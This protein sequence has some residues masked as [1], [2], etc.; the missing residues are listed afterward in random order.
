MLT[1]MNASYPSYNPDY[2]GD[3]PGKQNAIKVL[4][5]Q[6]QGNKVEFRYQENGA[7]LARADLIYTLN[8]GDRDE[9]WFRKPA[10]I[11]RDEHLVTVKL[12]PETTHYVINLIDENHFLRSYPEINK[13]NQS[14]SPQ[15]LSV[16]G[17]PKTGSRPST[18][19]A[20]KDADNDGRVSQQEYINHFAGGFDRKDKNQDGVLTPSEHAHPSFMIADTDEDKQLTRAEFASIFKRQFDRMDRDKNGFITADEID[21]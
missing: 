10:T 16:T 2:P 18:S 15:A 12:P 17:E 20:E 9:E 13:T 11:M 1:E 3:L 14:Y 5:H 4:S 21:R 7:K 19:I 6:K 8:G